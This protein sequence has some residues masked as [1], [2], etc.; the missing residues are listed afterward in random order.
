MIGYINQNFL[1]NLNGFENYRLLWINRLII[2]LAFMFAFG[3]THARLLITFIFL[4]WITVINREEVIT[5][6][7]KP[8]I[9]YFFIFLCTISLSIF[10]ISGEHIYVLKFLE[11]FLVYLLIPMIMIS[12]GV[13]KDYITQIITSFILGM[14][15]NEIV[16]Y[17]I[18][19]HFWLHLSPEGFPVYF[20]HHV[21]YSILLS[22]VLM[23]LVYKFLHEKK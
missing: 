22:F 9:F 14:I 6:F 21:F 4:L 1:F 18:L 12:T 5:T 13:R 11:R 3:E 7:K 23:L 19:F 17:G 16:S 10:Y 20:M 15:A 8:V 2:F